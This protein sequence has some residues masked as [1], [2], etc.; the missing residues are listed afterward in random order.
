MKIRVADEKELPMILQFLTEVKAYMDVVD[1]TQWTKDYPSQ[2]DIQEDIATSPN[3]I[4]KGYG[5]LLFHE[6]EKR[7]VW[8]GRRKMYAQTNHTNHRMI[9]FFESKG[10]TK[11][12]ESLQMN[13][14]DFGSFYLYVKELEKQ[15]IV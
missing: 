5:S 6:L 13:R 4:A 1:I 10:F 12:H 2:E 8:E 11:I 9:R 14:L 15:S 7:A 3:Y